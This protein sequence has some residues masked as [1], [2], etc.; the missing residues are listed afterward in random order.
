[1]VKLDLNTNTLISFE[2]HDLITSRL[3]LE[4]SM[5][6]DALEESMKKIVSE[7]N[8]FPNNYD[9][10]NRFGSLLALVVE[11][12]SPAVFPLKDQPSDCRAARYKS[13]TLSQNLCMTVFMFLDKF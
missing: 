10:A 6:S 4:A 13:I 12:I 5:E 11:W 2:V 8:S 9:S 7:T 1:M 3:I